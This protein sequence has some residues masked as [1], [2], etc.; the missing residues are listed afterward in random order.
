MIDSNMD[1]LVVDDASTMRRIIRGLLRELSLKNIREA[2]NGCDAL[3]ELRRKKADLVISD[4]NMP[5]MTGIE[6]LI[7]FKVEMSGDAL[8]ESI[9]ARDRV[10]EEVKHLTDDIG[11]D[12]ALVDELLENIK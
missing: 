9:D 8:Q 10:R 7:K 12:Q 5:Q 11:L 4:W 2:E 3:E 1:I 6:L